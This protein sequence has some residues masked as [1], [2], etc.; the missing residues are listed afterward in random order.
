MWQREEGG[1]RNITSI[2]RVRFNLDPTSAISSATFTICN[3]CFSVVS[4]WYLARSLQPASLG[5]P[6]KYVEDAL[7]IR[8]SVQDERARFASPPLSSS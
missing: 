4:I 2:R 3:S 5:P 7:R 1:N 6:T 8:S